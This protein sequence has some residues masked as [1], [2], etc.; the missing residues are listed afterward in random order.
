MIV[1]ALQVPECELDPPRPQTTTWSGTEL[2]I[3]TLPRWPNTTGWPSAWDLNGVDGRRHYL[4]YNISD[5]WATNLVTST[6]QTNTTL[7]S[8]PV[9]KGQFNFMGSKRADFP[10]ITRSPGNFTM[11][12]WPQT[13]S[14]TNST[15]QDVGAAPS[16]NFYF[17]TQPFNVSQVY[18]TSYKVWGNFTVYVTHQS[19]ND[20]TIACFNS[21]YSSMHG[22]AAN[23]NC[24][25]A[26]QRQLQCPF[27]FRCFSPEMAAAPGPRCLEDF[28]NGYNDTSLDPTRSGAPKDNYGAHFDG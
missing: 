10:T 18:N 23:I 5:G 27:T 24:T 3:N 26:A 1:C 4:Q 13:K 21:T 11:S 12:A 2:P 7:G 19:N 20:T 16:R 15:V 14:F 8:S 28:D 22:T 25:I 17:A 9:L 6:T